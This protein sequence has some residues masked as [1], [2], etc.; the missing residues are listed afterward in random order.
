LV[1]VAA[2]G[3]DIDIWDDRAFLLPPVTRQDAARA[4]R[5]LRIWPLLKGHRGRPA[6][7]LDGIECLMVSL[8]QLAVDVSEIAELDLNPVMVGPEHASVVD[9]KVRVAS[10]PAMDAGIPRRLR[11]TW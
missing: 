3:V 8:G 2:G 7:D 11:A 6:A 10:G 4:L 5:S 1:M 9:A